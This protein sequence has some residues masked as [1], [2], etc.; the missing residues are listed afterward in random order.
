MSNIPNGS[1]LLWIHFVFL[2]CAVAYGCWLIT[3]YY[4]ENISLQHSMF[5]SYIDDLKKGIAFDLSSG[6]QITDG[7]GGRR[8]LR[9]NVFLANLG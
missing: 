8:A 3:L 2:F 4:E 5:S 6:A 1:A 7:R 9:F